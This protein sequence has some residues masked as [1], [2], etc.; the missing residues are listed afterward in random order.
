MATSTRPDAIVVGTGPN[1]LAAAIRCA[2]AG[3]S[4]RVLE[5]AETPGGGARSAELTLPGFVHDVCSGIFPFA[6]A[7]PVFRSLPLAAHGL[8]FCHPAAP[9]AHPFDDGTAAVLARSVEQTADLLDGAD[10]ATYAHL[11]GPV[12]RDARRVM[13]DVLGPRRL[14]RHPLAF[15]RFAT[16]AVRSTAS[17]AA[18]FRGQR[19]R[20]LLAGLGTHAMLPL[21]QVPGAGFALVL[22]VLGHVV[23]WPLAQGGAQQLSLA[24]ASYLQSLGGELALGRRVDS[25]DELRA[26]LVLLEV[27]P[28]E[29][30]RIGGPEL[31]AGFRRQLRHYLP[32]PGVCKVDWALAAPV[33]WRAEACHQAGT[34]H[35]GGTFEEIAAAER[36]V[37]AGQHPA[38]PFVLV[39]QHSRFDP[40]RAPA[41]RHTLYAYCQVPNGSD[42]DMT[43][44]IESQIERFAPG[45]RARILARHTRTAA[46]LEA[47]NS[48]YVGGDILGGRNTL[49]QLIARPTPRLAPYATPLPGVYLCSAATP[50]GGGVHGM[51]GALAA[52]AALR[53]A[54]GRRSRPA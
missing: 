23:G 31:P 30:L 41:G 51:C 35:L 26:P 5:A 9:L 29:L 36:A 49:W 53:G 22:A 28:R 27:A 25:L 18:R 45:F 19:A 13:D 1:G 21:E 54:R 7:S 48:S 37:A 33:P 4:V 47:Y 8:A 42:V 14:P 38:R 6:A 50:P 12:V 43:E 3:L 44:R 39:A 17:L 32:G 15:A 10:R 52:E 11:I 34:L 16:L 24:L 46:Q 40:T 20:G 2:Q